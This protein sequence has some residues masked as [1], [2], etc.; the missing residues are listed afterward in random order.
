MPILIEKVQVSIKNGLIHFDFIEVEPRGK[1]NKGTELIEYKNNDFVMAPIIFKELVY[2][3]VD[4]I[5]DYEKIH[6]KI[7][8]DEIKRKPKKDRTPLK[9]ENIQVKDISYIG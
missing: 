3:L 8:I 9:I 1:D 2:T 4:A 6:G 5:D 7:P